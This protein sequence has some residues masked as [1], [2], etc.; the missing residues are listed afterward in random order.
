MFTGEQKIWTRYPLYIYTLCFEYI[1]IS[2]H[3]SSRANIKIVRRRAKNKFAKIWP[4]HPLYIYVWICIQIH[5]HTYIKWTLGSDFWRVFFSVANNFYVHRQTI[6]MFAGEQFYVRRWMIFLFAAKQFFCS[7]ANKKYEPD[8][9]FINIPYVLYS[10]SYV[11]I[12]KV[13]IGFRFLAGFF[14]L[15]A[16]NYY[17]HRRTIFMFTGE[18]FY[19]CRRMIVLFDAKQFLC[20]PANKKYEP[21]IHFIYIHYILNIYPYLYIYLRRR[22]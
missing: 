8:I 6:F 18:Q 17:V 22:T 11:Y 21:D 7:P 1:S 9:Q 14:C 20:S 16:N 13:Y 10:N 12:Y 5:I 2:I 3:I 19:V 4:W 15:V